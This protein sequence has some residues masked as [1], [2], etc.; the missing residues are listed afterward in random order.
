MAGGG[1]RG[2]EVVRQQR[3]I[4]TKETETRQKKG[5]RE[6]RWRGRET[7]CGLDKLWVPVRRGGRTRADLKH[8]RLL[9]EPSGRFTCAS[10]LPGAGLSL[11]HV[12]TT[13]VAHV[14]YLGY[15]PTYLPTYLPTCLYGIGHHMS[16]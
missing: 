1:G 11:G 6:E 15:R 12:G 5:G 9:A 10:G 13:T 2:K 7:V 3:I 4:S 16:S 14:T 8:H